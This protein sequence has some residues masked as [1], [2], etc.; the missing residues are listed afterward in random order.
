MKNYTP[1]RQELKKLGWHRTDR[2][3]GPNKSVEL[4]M[5]PIGINKS[6]LARNFKSACKAAGIEPTNEDE[7]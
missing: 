3:I 4:W 5:P 6:D 2:A 7:D 1:A